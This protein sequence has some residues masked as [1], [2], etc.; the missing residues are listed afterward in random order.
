VPCRATPWP[1]R[2][3]LHG[4]SHPGLRG[5]QPSTASGGG[6]FRD[7]PAA[8]LARRRVADATKAIPTWSMG[9]KITVI[10]HVDEQ[11]PGGDRGPLSVWPRYD[12]IE[13]VIHPQSINPL[14][15]GARRF[16]GA[17]P[18]R[19][20]DM[21]CRLAPLAQLPEALGPTPPGRRS[22]SPPWAQLS[23]RHPTRAIPLQ[24]L[25]LRA[26]PQRPAPCRRVMNAGQRAGC[27]PVPR[28]A[29]SL[30]D[31]PRLIERVLRPAHGAEVQ[32]A[33]TTSA[34]WL[35]SMPWA[36][37][38]RALKPQPAGPENCCWPD[39]PSSTPLTWTLP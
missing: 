9:R 14:D 32:G 23:S 29:R 3:P 27:R 37:H 39:R 35:A 10:R 15:G 18:A 12:A 24:A 28:R 19:L 17:R 38:A 20:A 13:I 22:I 36:R 16:L 4:H 33:I 25:G 21:N 11:G 6:L 7:W 26:G 34:T 1:Y 5:I 30:L 2:P 31:I 8:D